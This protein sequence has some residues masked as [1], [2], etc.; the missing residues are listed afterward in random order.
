MVTAVGSNQAVYE[1]SA[2]DSR[3]DLYNEAQKLWN[4]LNQGTPVSQL[5]QTQLDELKKLADETG[6]RAL[7]QDVQNLQDLKDSGHGSPA[8]YQR[9]L[10]QIM[11]DIKRG[12]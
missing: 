11:N 10:E 7:Q 6:S 1:A 12:R 4:E 5:S 3:Q 8:D 9:G 2:A